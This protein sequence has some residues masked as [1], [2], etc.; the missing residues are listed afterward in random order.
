M[1]EM[2]GGTCHTSEALCSTAEAITQPVLDKLK[3]YEAHNL[4]GKRPG[5]D[6]MRYNGM[7]CEGTTHTCPKTWKSEALAITEWPM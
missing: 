2:G 3:P 5:E 1:Y 6:C 4:R 7:I